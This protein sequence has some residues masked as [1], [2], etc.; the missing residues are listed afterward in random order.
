LK[1]IDIDG[2][3]TYSKVASVNFGR[4]ENIAVFPNPASDRL[5]IRMPDRSN[6]SSVR[7]MDAS[8]KLVLQR[9]IASS[10]IELDVRTLPKGWYVIQL[11]GD[12]KVEKI[13]VKE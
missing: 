3:F 9:D 11:I 13:F 1:Q 5:F 6:F 4:S 8:G 12:D 10:A 2:S 7:I